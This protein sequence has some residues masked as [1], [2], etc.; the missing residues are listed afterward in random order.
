VVPN[1]DGSDVLVNMYKSG[2]DSL[3]AQVINSVYNATKVN[4]ISHTLG[5][6]TSRDALAGVLRVSCSGSPDPETGAGLIV[7]ITVDS[8][9]DDLVIRDDVIPAIEQFLP[10]YSFNCSKDFDTSQTPTIEEWEDGATV[11]VN[12]S[13]SWSSGS[14]TG[15]IRTPGV[16]REGISF[17]HHDG[18]IKNSGYNEL[19]TESTATTSGTAR[20]QELWGVQGSLTGRRWSLITEYPRTSELIY[21]ITTQGFKH[22]KIGYEMFGRTEEFDLYS[23]GDLETK[24]YTVNPYGGSL[25]FQSAS[26]S[27]GSVLLNGSTYYPH[28]TD[29]NDIGLNWFRLQR[30]VSVHA[31][32]RHG[33]I[34]RPLPIQNLCFRQRAIIRGFFA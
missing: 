8:E 4:V 17:K 6:F 31:I 28:G 34:H 13:C 32:Q 18:D 12:C 16:D 10:P 22:Q 21:T 29:W 30:C 23:I 2:G 7:S 9:Y 26:T 11:I 19:W 20:W 25:H 27:P 5:E 14:G 33:F 24:V 15:K 3:G 1:E